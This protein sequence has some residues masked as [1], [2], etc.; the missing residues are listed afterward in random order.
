MKKTH[1]GKKTEE[2]TKTY[3]WFF[4]DIVS[5]AHPSKPTKEQLE[6]IQKFYEILSKTTIMHQ[7]D[8]KRITVGGGDG[9]IIGFPDSAE[10]PVLLA[11]ELLQKLGKYNKTK[12]GKEKILLRI[13]IESGP[14]YVIKDPITKRNAYWGP[15]VIMAK[16][17]MDIGTENHILA[18]KRISEDIMKLSKEYK[19]LFHLIGEYEIKHQEKIEIYN[20]YGK[21]FGNRIFPR[22]GKEMQKKE[23]DKERRS[24][25]NFKFKKIEINLEIKNSKSMMAHHTFV[26]DLVNI[27]EKSQPQILY[28]LGGEKKKDISELNI[29]VTDSNSKNL[30]IIRVDSNKPLY[31]EFFVRLKQPIKPRREL[32]GIKLEYDWEEPD[33]EFSFVLPTDC[34]KF[35]YNLSIPNEAEPKVRNFKRVGL[36]EKQP[37]ESVIKHEKKTTQIFWEGKNLNAFDEYIFQW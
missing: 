18:S 11:R 37:L 7:K 34:K 30:E 13:G 9:H 35:S 32:K 6:K 10:K 4:C 22:K 25:S 27:S 29:R 2:F 14:V 33:R 28:Q 19:S 16:R 24:T 23:T 5:S 15:G 3:H 31:K 12:R 21:D 1:L 36:R 17:V 20:I 8:P 26:W